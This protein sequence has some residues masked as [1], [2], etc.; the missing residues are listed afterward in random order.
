[1]VR[2]GILAIALGSRY[3]LKV[4]YAARAKPRDWEE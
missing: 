1:M 3:P 2:A 4:G